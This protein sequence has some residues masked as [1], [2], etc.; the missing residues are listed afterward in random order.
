M[1]ITTGVTDME[2]GTDMGITMVVHPITAVATP[3][4]HDE[5]CVRT[6]PLGQ[7]IRYARTEVL[8]QAI[9]CRRS[10]IKYGC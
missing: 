8:S 10:Q 9:G 3:I 6:T 7:Q 2:M 4:A 1:V 5:K